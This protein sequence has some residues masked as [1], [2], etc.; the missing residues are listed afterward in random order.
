MRFLIDA[1]LPAS[2]VVLLQSHGHDSI[3][4]DN[5]PNKESSTDLEI[6]K[7]ADSEGR[8]VI[9]KDYDFLDS[10]YFQNSPQKLLLITTGNLKNQ[11]LFELIEFNIDHIV[12][13]FREYT[14][15]ELSNNEI[16]GH[17]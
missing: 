8:I 6:R 7:L 11:R 17:E 13:L 1:Q 2:L 14:F 5:L 15:V 9:T 3:H 16:I 12:Q 10:Y 4:T